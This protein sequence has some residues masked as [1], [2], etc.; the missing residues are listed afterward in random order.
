MADRF[1]QCLL[2]YMQNGKIRLLFLY[3][4]Y[5]LRPEVPGI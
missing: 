5:R 2:T 1:C 4:V 3:N